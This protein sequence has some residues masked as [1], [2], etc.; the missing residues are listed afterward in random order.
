M[1]IFVVTIIG[2]RKAVN[3]KVMLE[4]IAVAEDESQALQVIDDDFDLSGIEVIEKRAIN[5]VREK[6]YFI[7]TTRV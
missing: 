6:S 1:K 3:K 4:F 5:H 7:K 2:I